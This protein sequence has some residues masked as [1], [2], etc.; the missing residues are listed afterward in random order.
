MTT[1]QFDL[2]QILYKLEEITTAFKHARNEVLAKGHTLDLDD[3][4][5]DLE[6]LYEELQAYTDIV[7]AG[8][9]DYLRH[10]GLL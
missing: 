6:L 5:T 1:P 2:T 4:I 3:L 10:G 9:E 8:G 7:C